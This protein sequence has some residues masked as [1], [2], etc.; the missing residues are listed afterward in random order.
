MMGR[1]K[2]CISSDCSAFSGAISRV[3]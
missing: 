2:F 1:V 3:F